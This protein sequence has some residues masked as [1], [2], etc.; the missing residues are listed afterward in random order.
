MNTE[1]ARG[2]EQTADP[3]EV[4]QVMGQLMADLAASSGM[5]LTVIGVRTGLW[6]SLAAEP[7]TPSELAARAS[8]S[9]PYVRE[10]LRSQAAAGY[11]R[12]EPAS[13][14]YSPPAAVAVLMTGEPLRGLV[15]GTGLQAAAQ[16]AEVA[17]R[18]AAERDAL[19]GEL[20]R[21]LG[22]G[23]RSR[24]LG[25]DSERARKAVTARIH[26]AIDHLQ[27]YHPDLAAHHRAAICTGTACSYQPAEPVGWNQ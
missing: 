2:T 24:R 11:V 1:T 26:H 18:A 12:Y 10:W 3:A 21:A 25:D 20:S 7:A 5:L 9:E 23:G 17:A 15:E 13:G 4:G 22:L 6:E 27:N 19:I 8:A 16:W 14:R